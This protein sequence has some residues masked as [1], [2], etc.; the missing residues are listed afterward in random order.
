VRRATLGSM[1][2][3]TYGPCSRTRRE[4]EQKS[5]EDFFVKAVACAKDGVLLHF[6]ND[7]AI[8]PAR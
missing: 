4:A 6:F 1:P 3:R 7:D 8:V 5:P 2:T